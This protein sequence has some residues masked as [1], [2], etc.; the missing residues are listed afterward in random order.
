[1]NWAWNRKTSCSMTP[2]V[3]CRA[4]GLWAAWVCVFLLSLAGCD[5][6]RELYT[7][8][9]PIM[10]TSWSVKVVGLPAGVS[11]P[12]LQSDIRL[13]L[14]SVNNQMSTWD[15]SSAISGYNQA[16]AGTRYAVPP[17]LFQ[18]LEFA[19]ELAR[20]TDGAYDPTIGPLVSLWGFGPDDKAF[21]PPS[22]QALSKTRQRIGW[23]KLELDR[24]KRR[25]LQPGGVGLDLSSVAKGYAVD[26]LAEFLQAR[27]AE[28]FLVE[29]GGELRAHGEKPGGR[30]WRVAVEKPQSGPSR[31]VQ[32]VVSLRERAMATSGDYRN[33][34]LVD[35]ERVSHTLDPR[36][37]QPVEHE[38][39]SVTVLASD[40]MRADALAT[41]LNVM[42]PDQGMAFARQR[43]LA[44]LMLI[45][46]DEGGLRE[47]ATERFRQLREDRESS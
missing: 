8:S 17:D 11:R 23:E 26:K 16:E 34:H 24:D 36:T 1:M 25:V 32:Q 12:Q 44:V 5:S 15:E 39:A 46:S 33:F 22:D 31:Q 38:L 10:G 9:G 3:E 43:S 28:A 45:R 47:K 35:G 7:L 27:G 37:G 19:L 6:S 2:V 41:A 20:D 14:E 42:G 21:E 30:A 18:V 4:R 29:I 40:C 13:L